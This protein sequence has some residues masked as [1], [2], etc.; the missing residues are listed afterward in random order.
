[1]L[2]RSAGVFFGRRQSVAVP[3]SFRAAASSCVPAAPKL[4]SRGLTSA[5]AGAFGMM[6]VR[7][8]QGLRSREVVRA[9]SGRGR[10]LV[11]SSS[12]SSRQGLVS[13]A[14]GF[15]VIFSFSCGECAMAADGT[16]PGFALDSA[17]LA[18]GLGEWIR[19]DTSGLGAVPFIAVHIVAI[20]LCF[21][22]TAIFELTAGAVFGFLPGV[23]VVASAK[24][25][26]AAVTFFI[27]RAVR[28]GPPGR[29]IQE[30]LDQEGQENGGQSWTEKL[31]RGVRR[32]AFRFCLLARLSPVP[33]WIN[34]YALPLAG[35]SLSSFLPATFLG[36]L[37]PL[38]SNVYSGSAAASVAAALSRGSGVEFDWIGVSLGILSTLSEAAIVQQLAAVALEEDSERRE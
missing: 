15:F 18:A 35:V 24:G 7:L 37:P 12:I 3:Q 28:D 16:S 34:N 21:P 9:C 27:A 19:G 38:A 32:D 2:F 8:V 20:I 4:R 13:L 36:M 10:R 5:L 14:V 11:V 23:I 1:M 22:G 33:S 25:L 29:W 26:A 17:S 31:K 30:R 6:G